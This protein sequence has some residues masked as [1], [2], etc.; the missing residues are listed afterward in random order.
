MKI[1]ILRHGDAI[2]SN[3]DR[4]L[5]SEGILEATSTGAKLSKLLKL[6]KCFSSPKTRAMQTAN[7]VAE[8]M[9]FKD[10]I[11]SLPELTPS[12]D[13]HHVIDFINA[14]CSENDVVLLVSHLP[15]VETLSYDFNQKLVI[16]PRFDTACALIMEYDGIRAKYERY[17]SPNEN[18][19]LF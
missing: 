13:A 15:L 4:V 11:E 7:I 8:Q 2:F 5:S 9:D 17:V 6:T 19:F 10:K 16:P 18:D 1:V 14:T 12:G 3:A